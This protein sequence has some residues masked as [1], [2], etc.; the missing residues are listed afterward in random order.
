MNGPPQKPIT[1]FSAG[2][3]ARTS[4][5]ASSTGRERLVGIG[6]AQ[7]LDVRE[8]PDR[9]LDHRADALDELDVDAHAEHGGHDV[10]EQHGRVDV[11]T[12]DRLQRHLGAELGCPRELEERVPLPQRAILGQR[13]PGLPHEPDGRALHLLAPESAH[14]KRLGHARSVAAVAQP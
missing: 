5:T 11:V 7:P 2:S 6:D 4:R 13:A 10:R 1:A 12:P 14:Q 9:P 3:S 8:R